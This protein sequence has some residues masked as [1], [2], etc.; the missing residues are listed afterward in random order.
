MTYMWNNVVEMDTCWKYV[1][2]CVSW[3]MYGFIYHFCHCSLLEAD[4]NNGESRRENQKYARIYRYLTIGHC[5]LVFTCS[6]LLF[7]QHTIRYNIVLIFFP[8]VLVREV[9]PWPHPALLEN[10]FCIGNINMSWASMKKV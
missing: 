9:D 10:G 1:Q 3:R 6:Q 8:R 2:V 4:S 7:D 5:I